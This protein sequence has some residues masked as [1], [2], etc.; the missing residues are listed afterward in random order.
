MVEANESDSQRVLL[1]FVSWNVCAEQ[2]KKED[3]LKIELCI[4]FWGGEISV[5]LLEG[6]KPCL[7]YV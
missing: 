6:R 2:N 3:L 4:V 1:V 7:R 5:N